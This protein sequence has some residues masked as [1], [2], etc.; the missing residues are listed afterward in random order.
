MNDIVGNLNIKETKFVFVESKYVNDFLRGKEKTINR[1]FD[2]DYR[3]YV[4]AMKNNKII[5]YAILFD[6]EKKRYN[7]LSNVFTLSNIEVDNDFRRQGV[8]SGMIDLLINVVK[9]EGRILKRTTPD[10]LGKLY[11]FDK[12]SE[13]AKHNNVYFIP[14]NLVFIYEFIEKNGLF[15]NKN[16]DSKM[17]FFNTVCNNMLK[18]PKIKEWDIDTLDELNGGF[19]D[20]IA[21]VISKLKKPKNK[22]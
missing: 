20:V 12:I 7:S 1:T 11:I 15:K 19:H 6:N 13:V 21:D 22:L 10:V 18:H 8:A 17:K 3:N 16:N 9:S 14:H 2:S 4:F 5:G